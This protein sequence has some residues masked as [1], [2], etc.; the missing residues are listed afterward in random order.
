M[1]LRK[2]SQ[3]EQV[4]TLQR[5][6]GLVADGDFGPRTEAAV[7]TWQKNNGLVDDGI[8]GPRTWNAM[9]LA[10]TDITEHIAPANDGL[11]FKKEYLPKSEYFA[12]PV[13]KDWI[14]LH[15]TAGWNDPYATIKA[16]GRDTRGAIA[17]EWVLGGQKITDNDSRYDGD[18]V[19]AFPEGGYG[20]HLG[21]GNNVMHR[22]SVGIELC[23]FGFVT[24]GGYWKWNATTK[25]NVWIPLKPNSFYTY[26][27]TEAHPDQLVTLSKA[28]RGH[29]VWHKYSDKQITVLKDW[30]L[31]V[32]NRDNIDPRKG[33]IEQIK[34]LGVHEA[35]DLVDVALCT[36]TP[37]MWLHTN[38]QKG[39]VDLFPQEELVD[40]LLSL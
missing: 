37:G 30:I 6:L 34:K 23:N 3:G 7:K 32:A 40:M 18:L 13:P 20:W 33:L 10:T 17:T 2:G 24:K 27:G 1:I 9:G 14:F 11:S 29:S 26:V 16:W 8:V 12:G 22:N 19:Q 38:V 36:R 4:K 28:F 31:Y 39:K 15:H 35:F 5:Y 25:K 21:T